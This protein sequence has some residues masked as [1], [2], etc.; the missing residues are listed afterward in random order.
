MG[1]FDSVMVPCPKCGEESEF[2]SKSGDCILKV[3]PLATAPA[4]VLSNVNRHSPATCEKC[5]TIFAVKIGTPSVAYEI[6][7]NVGFDQNS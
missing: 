7:N 1:M 3:Y 2:Q 4:D 6:S 5:G